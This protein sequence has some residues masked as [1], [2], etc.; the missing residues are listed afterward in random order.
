MKKAIIIGTGAQAKYAVNNM[1]FQ[2]ETLIEGLIEVAS[3]KKEERLCSL[4]GK[5][6]LGGLEVLQ[7]YSKEEISLVVALSCH[8][9]KEEIAKSLS[10]KGF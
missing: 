1:G 5:P 4:L 8:K 9:Q 6:V 7:K 10:D 3:E 2:K